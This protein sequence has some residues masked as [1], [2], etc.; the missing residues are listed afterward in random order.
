MSSEDKHFPLETNIDPFFLVSSWDEALGPK[1]LAEYPNP[2]FIQS[3]LSDYEPLSFATQIFMVASS[4]FGSQEYKKEIVDLPIV[5][6]EKRIRARVI[7][8]FQEVPETEVRGGR[9]PF[10]FIVGY[11]QSKHHKKMV[12]K[13]QPDLTDL[14]VEIIHGNTKNLSTELETNW[15]KLFDALFTGFDT[16]DE[17]FDILLYFSRQ[18]IF[19]LITGTILR[20][21]IP[22]QTFEK[23][24]KQFP[25]NSY[26]AQCIGQIYIKEPYFEYWYCFWSGPFIFFLRPT[27]NHL[28]ELLRFI[29]NIN[30]FQERLWTLTMGDPHAG[31]FNL[32]SNIEVSPV[33]TGELFKLSHMSVTRRLTGVEAGLGF[34]HQFIQNPEILYYLRDQA[35]EC[36]DLHFSDIGTPISLMVHYLEDLRNIYS[37][38]YWPGIFSAISYFFGELFNKTKSNTNMSWYRTLLL[39]YEKFPDVQVQ[40]K[41]R[42]LHVM[43]CP[44]VHLDTKVG[45]FTFIRSFLISQYPKTKFKIILMDNAEF[46][47]TT[48]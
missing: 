37:E 34:E 19:G 16:I 30:Q 9:L 5:S 28:Q 25:I 45:Y 33:I 44:F 3:S 36:F 23:N 7:F 14:L 39:F 43:N 10:M 41:A 6:F 40:Q 26:K 8:D 22:E 12:D 35:R 4:L 32:F 47:I 29:N 21:N 17:F 18:A 27:L 11:P 20:Q 1:I 38:E 42:S 13:L 46:S 31:L 15:N 24:L 2:S 48:L